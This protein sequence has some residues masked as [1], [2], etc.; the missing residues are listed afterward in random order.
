MKKAYLLPAVLFFGLNVSSTHA[1]GFHPPTSFK[2]A[3]R[4]LYTKVYPGHGHTLYTG[5]EWRKKKVD[6]ESCG[7]QDAFSK[8][9]RKWAKRIEAEHVIP[10]S[11]FYRKN[12]HLRQ[13]AIMAKALGKGERKYCREHIIEYRQAHNDLVNLYPAVGAINGMRSAK[14]FAE[15][16]SGGRKHTFRGNRTI[17]ITNRVAVPDR[18][19]SPP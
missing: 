3:K 17:V 8:K 4:A 15:R 7:L 14:P 12:G 16:P 19:F 11:W 9:W 2:A 5:C 1:D 13:C 18:D 6:L 10:A